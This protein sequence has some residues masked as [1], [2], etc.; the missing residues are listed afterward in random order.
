MS[1]AA[2]SS[3]IRQ[4]ENLLRL[5]LPPCCPL[6]N[7]PIA[8]GDLAHRF[9]HACLSNM[10]PL[11]SPC[12]TRCA[13]PFAPTGGEDHLCETC[14]RQR[15]AYDWVA[16]AGPYH[17]ALRD[18]VHAF[19]F[20]GRLDLD[21]PLAALVF[22][23]LRERLLSFA[24]DVLVPVPLS[25]QRLRQRTFNQSYL[26][27]KRLS[28]LLQCPATTRVLRQCRAH[29]SQRE[30][31]RAQRLRN[32]RGAYQ[33][34]SS[35]AGRRLLLI[36]DVVTTGATSNECARVLRKAGATAI[37]VVAVARAPRHV[38]FSPH[39]LPQAAVGAM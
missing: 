4:S 11:S 6:C 33:V 13:V 16:A 38:D 39:L 32:P 27:A 30:L 34:T 5:F 35:V 23:R 28:A 37:G 3:F 20:S 12:C 10:P 8:E 25:S 14:A 31:S 29:V 9:C 17:G 18:A 26:L 24:P 19:K 15:P 7:A 1:S 36:D 22:G 2:I 21:R